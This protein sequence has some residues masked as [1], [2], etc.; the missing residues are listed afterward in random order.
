[1]KYKVPGTALF[2]AG[3]LNDRTSGKPTLM[4]SFKFPPYYI[5][6]TIT[7]PYV[8]VLQIAK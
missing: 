3:I 5:A 1:M 7:F 4:G 8:F 6:Q 2:I